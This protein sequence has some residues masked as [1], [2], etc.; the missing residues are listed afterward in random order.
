MLN[1]RKM[2]TALLKAQLNRDSLCVR[3]HF[4][5]L[6][7]KI[8]PLFFYEPLFALEAKDVNLLFPVVL[9]DGET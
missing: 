9:K 8:V 1:F 5:A 6:S 7:V 2:F 3:T 4:A